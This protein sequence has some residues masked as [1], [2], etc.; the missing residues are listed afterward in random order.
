VNDDWLDILLSGSY[1]EILTE[2]AIASG[3]GVQC[4]GTGRVF[5]RPDSGLRIQA[6]TEGADALFPMIVPALTP[7]QLIPRDSFITT[8]GRTLDGWDVWV[9]PVPLDGYSVSSGSPSALWDLPVRLLRLSQS[10]DMVEGRFI[11]AILGPPPSTWVRW[12]ETEIRNEQFP[13]RS[14]RRDWL[15]AR[16]GIGTVAARKRS[17]QWFEVKAVIEGEQP[18]ADAATILTAVARAFGFVLGRRVFVRGHQ[19]LAEGKETRSLAVAAGGPTRG[20]LEAPI[21]GSS[22]PLAA[23]TGGVENLLGLAIDFFLTERG[24]S[25]ARLLHLC[26]DSADNTWATRRAVAGIAV[27]GLLRIAAGPGGDPGYTPGE[28]EAVRRWLSENPANLS[29][30]FAARLQGLLGM[31][32]NRRPVDVL[33]DW[34]GRGLLGVT[35]EDVEAWNLTR[36]PAAHARAVGPADSPAELQAQAAR[37]HR[38]VNLMNRVVLQLMGYRGRHVDYSAPGWPE[39]EFPAAPAGSL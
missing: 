1:E 30:R 26:W 28:M 23:Y 27:E 13:G 6:V 37:Y 21:G 20:D 31:M 32:G 25:V 14:G 35:A 15:L 5:W 36:N 24:E 16:P 34:Q 17:D 4:R 33:R 18:Q 7:G 22:G 38:V 9:A 8:T 12:T 10:N 39:V 19:E 3:D 11:R 2:L 29:P